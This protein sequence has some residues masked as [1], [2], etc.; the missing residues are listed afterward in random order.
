VLTRENRPPI[1]LSDT[2]G[3]LKRLPHELVASFHS[4]LEMVRDADLLLHVV[5][6]G[7]KQYEEHIATTEEVLAEI[8]AG[9]NPRMLVFNKIDRLEDKLTLPMARKKFPEAV[10]ISALQDDGGELLGRVNAFFEKSMVTTPLMLEYADSGGLAKIYKWGRVDEVRYEDDGI[11]L[12]VTST[13]ANLER[14]RSSL[15][16]AR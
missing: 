15:P 10:F 8:G 4:T 6:I 7:H 12:T 14:I 1:L 3:F 16:A 13:P 11:H 2:V 5:D 9:T